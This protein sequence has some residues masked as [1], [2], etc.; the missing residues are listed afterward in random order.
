MGL[1]IKEPNTGNVFKRIKREIYYGKKDASGERVFHIYS[2]SEFVVPSFDKIIVCC[3]RLLRK[4][5]LYPDPENLEDP[6]CFVF[7]DYLSKKYLCTAE[8]SQSLFIQ[9]R[10]TWF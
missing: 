8:M 7:V 6:S 1:C 9:K 3:S 10:M 2:D 4:F 5:I